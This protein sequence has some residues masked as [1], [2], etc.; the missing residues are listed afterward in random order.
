MSG[1][2]KPVKNQR[3]RTDY[4][5]Q[6]R[7]QNRIDP[8]GSYG[9]ASLQGSDDTWLTGHSNG[10]TDEI[11]VGKMPLWTRIWKNKN[12]IIEVII[13]PLLLVFIGFIAKWVFDANADVKVIQNQIATIESRIDTLETDTLTKEY[14]DLKVELLKRDVSSLIPDVSS[15]EEEIVAI[16][17]RL[18]ELEG[19]HE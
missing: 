9:S 3:E 10:S 6:S 16:N 18:D 19:S 7:R 11:P 15:I 13:I 14:F 5:R 12:K 1:K 4:Y 2:H 8:T 17:S